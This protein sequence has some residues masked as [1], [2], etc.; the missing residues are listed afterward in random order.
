MKRKQFA[1]II[2]NT[3]HPYAYE[4]NNLLALPDGFS[5]RVRFRRRWIACDNPYDLV[6]CEGLIL[7]RVFDTA[8]I[9]P[10]RRAEIDQ[11]TKAGDIVFIGFRARELIEFSS[12]SERRRE[13]L[14][15]FNGLVENMLGP[16]GN[17]AGQHMKAG[18]IPATDP[19]FNIRDESFSGSEQDRE[20]NSWGNLLELLGEVDCYQD[21]DFLKIVEITDSAGKMVL[22]KQTRIGRLYQLN[23]AQ[24]YILKIL[25]LVPM[26]TVVRRDQTKEGSLYFK[27]IHDK[28]LELNAQSGEIDFLVDRALLTGRYDICPFY[29]RT[30]NV[31]NTATSAIVVALRRRIDSELQTRAEITIPIAITL[32]RTRQTLRIASLV[33][34]FTSGLIVLFPEYLQNILPMISFSTTSGGITPIQRV[35]LVVMVLTS[36]SLPAVDKLISRIRP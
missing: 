22:S 6:G 18:I 4:V 27:E 28:C 33:L 16:Y 36:W 11:V 30:A 26:S 5:Q 32:S 23:S 9:I 12:N 29:F 15:E 13:Q 17:V 20:V 8:Q 21:F 24:T 34:L 14:Q 2:I 7:L 31:L 25:Q 19:T 1:L 35:A 3:I 10:L